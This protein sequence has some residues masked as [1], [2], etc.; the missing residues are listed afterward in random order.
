VEFE[1]E[2]SDGVL[3]LL[4]A[5]LVEL[6]AS[7]RLIDPEDFDRE[8]LVEGDV[9]AELPVDELVRG[10]ALEE[11]DGDVPDVLEEDVEGLEG[12]V[13]GYLPEDGPDGIDPDVDG[14]E[15]DLEG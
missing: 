12:D 3:A 8:S 6:P 1:D 14:F 11:F 5:A 10:G 4:D 2:V 15:L 9:A 7:A 13:D